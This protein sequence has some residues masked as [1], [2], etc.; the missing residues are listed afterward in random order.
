MTDYDKHTEKQTLRVWK[1]TKKTP[2]FKKFHKKVKHAL[3][4]YKKSNNEPLEI[5]IKLKNRYLGELI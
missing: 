1:K 2:E 4:E 3:E 5:T